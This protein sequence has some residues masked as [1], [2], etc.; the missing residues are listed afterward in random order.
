MKG[1]ILSCVKE[2][3]EKKFGAAAWTKVLEAAGQ[4]GALF[5]A[6]GDVPDEKAMKILGAASKV[7][8]LSMQALMDAFGDYW[9][10]DYSDKMYPQYY[11][12]HKTAKDFLRGMDA[13]HERL[14]KSIPNAK[15]PRFAYESETPNSFVMIYRSARGLGDMLPGLIAGVAR[16]Y[17][18]KIAVKKL[19]TDRFELKFA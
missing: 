10:N 11:A 12:E 19:G 17:R 5:L 13:L 4:P 3:V 6:G 1:T 15:P 18:T 8:G 16:H 2:L 9:A 14:T 7:S